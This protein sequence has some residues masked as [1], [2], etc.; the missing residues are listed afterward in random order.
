MRVCVCVGFFF[1]IL[2]GG[3]GGWEGEVGS[4]VIS[5]PPR[6]GIAFSPSPRPCASVM[7]GLEIINGW[8]SLDVM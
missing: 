8:M 7:P 3:K 6:F 2:E 1:F 5:T 4:A